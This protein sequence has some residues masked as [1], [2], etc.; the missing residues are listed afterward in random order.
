M[1]LHSGIY[2]GW[3]RHRRFMPHSHEFRYPV[4]MMY[5]D[6]DELDEVFSQTPTWSTRRGAPARFCRAD[7]LG[8]ES[9]T[10]KQAVQDCVEAKTGVRPSGPI[11]MLTNIRY[12]GFIINPITCYYCF[13]EQERLQTLVAEVTNTPWKERHAYVLPCDPNQKVQ[14]ITFDKA[15]HVSP[16]HP[17]DMTYRMR[18]SNP[19][20]ESSSLSLHLENWRQGNREFDASLTLQRQAITARSLNQVLWQYPL[21]TLQVCWGIYWN[22]AKLWFKRVPFYSHPEQE[23]VKIQ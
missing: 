8:D 13:D 2:Q 14:R 5:L 19:R 3:V 12:F 6:L 17:M 15:M 7:Y 21:M 22:A 4:F 16:F 20:V 9:Q 10:L 18:C 11:R 1:I 23:Q